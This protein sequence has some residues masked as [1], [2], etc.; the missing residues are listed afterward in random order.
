MSSKL[1]E[2][3]CDA[4]L[5]GVK[6]KNY[7]FYLAVEFHQFFGMIYAA[8]R[9]VGY[10]NKTVYSA[11][12]YE[13]TIIGDILDSTLE[14]LAF[15][16]L[17]NEFRTL[18]FLLGLEKSLMG[19]NHIAVLLIYLYYLEINGLTYILVVV[20][21]RLDVDLAAGQK[22]LYAEHIHNHTALSAGF[23]EAL[24]NLVILVCFVY[25]IPALESACLAM[26]ENQLP[27]PVF[28]TFYKYFHLIA[29]FELGIIAE[30]SGRDYA[31]ALAADC[32]GYF[33]LAY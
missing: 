27:M 16:K 30:F 24:H 19:N 32:D 20:A 10:M 25:T 13:Y 11:E 5:L 22:C 6:V 1:F 8:P 7:N 17:G 18:G 31:F 12:V 21:D 28:C 2:T 3:E 4:L 29:G 14:Y 33:A 9:K 23:Y 15:F 26:A